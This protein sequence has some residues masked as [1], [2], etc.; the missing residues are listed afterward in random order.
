MNHRHR[1][2]R[3]A[4]AAGAVYALAT[5]AFAQ[6]PADAL[7]DG[8]PG[9]HAQ[10]G[11]RDGARPHH[12]MHGRAAFGGIEHLHGLKLDEAQRDK[13]FEIRHGA[14]PEA[15]KAR[16]EINEA[17]RALV[18]LTRADKFD[19]AKAK[20]AADRQGAAIAKAALLRAKTDSQVLAVL[21]P[22]QRKTL[23]DH[24]ERMQDRPA[25]GPQHPHGGPAPAE[26]AS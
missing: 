26:L 16:K 18:E 20:A 23:A 7:S 13:I 6:A 14:A 17:R 3:L 25:R 5:P 22:E 19:D 1:F 15:R 2:A 24:R 11:P 9:A 10:Y 12:A 8:R 21:T 4:L